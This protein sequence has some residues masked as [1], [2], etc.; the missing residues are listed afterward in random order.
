MSLRKDPDTPALSNG[1]GL[2]MIHKIENCKK[3]SVGLKQPA[4]HNVG[5]LP[6]W[7]RHQ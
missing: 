3:F 7:L 5:K 6:Y 1:G 2:V 4:V